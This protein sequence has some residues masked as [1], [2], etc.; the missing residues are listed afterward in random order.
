MINLL[1]N[2]CKYSPEGSL[3]TIGAE[4]NNGEVIFFVQDE[5]L[6]IP[7]ELREKVFERFYR[8]DNS[9]KRKEVGTGI[10]LALAKEIITAHGWRIWVEANSPAGSRVLFALRAA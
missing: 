6:G 10:G 2:A 9:D 7:A 8:I 1:S 4:Y 5:G 3:V